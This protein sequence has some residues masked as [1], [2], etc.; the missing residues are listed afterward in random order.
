MI[1]AVWLLGTFLIVTV[2]SGMAGR[3]GK[4]W[5]FAIYAVSIVIANVTASK[6]M[7]VLGLTVAAADIIYAIGFTTIDLINEYYGKEEAKRAIVTALFANLLWAYSAYVAVKLPAADVF[8]EMQPQFEAVLGS[9][10]RIVLASMIAYYIASRVDVGVYHLIRQRGG[11]VWAR[12]VGSNAASLLVDSV[13]F[14]TIAFYGVFPLAEVIVGQYLIKIVI[15]LL[16]VPFAYMARAI[17]RVT[18]VPTIAVGAPSS[19]PS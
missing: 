8:A 9:A 6:L 19:G 18:H 2:F 12:I 4:G 1:W 7:T 16:N 17:Y 14:S 10:P 13:L 11:P 3:F 15:T 5:L